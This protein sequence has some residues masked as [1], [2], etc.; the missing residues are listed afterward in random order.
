[1][2]QVAELASL[3][4][5]PRAW[6]SSCADVGLDLPLGAG[7]PRRTT[8]PGAALD[9]VHEPV[10]RILADYVAARTGE[11]C[12]VEP[13][14]AVVGHEIAEL[15]A[16]GGK[17]LRPAFVYWGHRATGAGDD[18]GVFHVAAAVEML[19]TFALLHDDVMDRATMRRGRAS[20]QRSF[21]SVHLTDGL[22][23]DPAWFGTS[24]AILAGDLAFV[25]ADDLLDR[26]GLSAAATVR[27][28]KVFTG[29]RTE[30][31]AGQY[32]DLRLDRLGVADVA[33]ARRVALLKSG[34]YTV[35]RPLA[36][37]RA[38]VSG[39]D[40]STARGLLSYGDALGL[41]FQ[42]RDDVL[43]LFGDPART[44]KC[45][46]S[47][48]REGKRTV[49]ILRALDLATPPERGV[50]ERALGDPELDESGAA[51]CREIVARTGA[52]ASVETLVRTQHATAVEAIDRL[53]EPARGALRALAAAVVHRE[54]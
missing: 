46:T 32:L 53:P 49:L 54:Y 19:H 50:L 45:S 47:D 13:S 38:I 6:S 22:A 7:L 43:G 23:G 12:A 40:A 18:P 31:M 33:A 2:R 35:T 3:G 11:L 52:L 41:A 9:P 1:V 14:L 10:E 51:R 25:W 39:G 4:P 15:V 48:L 36:L 17:R 44:G 42:M 34:R 28:R 26:A 29:L 37:G 5:S 30:V 24:A 16:A 20:A 27:V 8:A 21:E